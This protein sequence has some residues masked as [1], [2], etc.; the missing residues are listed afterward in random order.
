MAGLKLKNLMKIILMTALAVIFGGGALW[1]FGQTNAP[2]AGRKI[3]YY[4]C[5]MHPSV[6]SGKPGNCPLCSMELMAVYEDDA[7]TN[8]SMTNA[9]RSVTTNA[10]PKP[11]P[12][13]TCLVDGM[14]LDSMGGPCAFVYQGQ[15]I[16][17]CC[18]ACKPVFLKDPAK[19][20]KKIQDARAAK[21]SK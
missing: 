7:A 11:Y 10:K 6:K 17:L 2:S 15:E 18:P 19:Y 4:T 5:P 20:M 13:D 9:A 12:F 8:N 3:L 14:K 1:L 16:K 21:N